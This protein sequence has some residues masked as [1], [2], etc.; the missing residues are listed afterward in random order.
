MIQNTKDTGLISHGGRTAIPSGRIR[1][2]LSF[3]FSSFARIDPLGL[4]LFLSVVSG[5]LVR[6]S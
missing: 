3:A 6:V 4:F 2:N 1:Q 5:D